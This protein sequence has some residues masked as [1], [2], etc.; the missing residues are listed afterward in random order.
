VSITGRSGNIAVSP[1]VASSIKLTAPASVDLGVPAS[2]TVTAYDAFGN[3]ATGTTDPIVLTSSDTHAVLPPQT[4]MVAGT[5]TEPVTFKTLGSVTL[6]ASVPQMAAL[7]ATASISVIAPAL[8]TFAAGMQ[9]IA[10]PADYTGYTLSTYF[11]TAPTLFATYV[12]NQISYNFYPQSPA[13]AIHPGVG[14]FANFS[15]ASTLL[16]FGTDT[17]PTQSFSITLWPGWNMIGDPYS[18]AIDLSTSTI[19]TPSGSVSFLVAEQ[20]HLVSTTLYTLRPGDTGYETATTALQPF[21]GY[22]FWAQ[23][24]CILTISPPQ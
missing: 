5:L 6:T 7:K 22:W 10:A 14:Y 13:D 12:P 8:H 11:T 17:K 16:D 24:P 15:A 1:A 20:T 2:I 18:M 19:Q 9:M 21:A 4:D 23:N 3:I